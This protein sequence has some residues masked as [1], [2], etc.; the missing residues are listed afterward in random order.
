M[1][2]RSPSAPDVKTGRKISTGAAAAPW[3][4]AIR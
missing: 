1:A 4:H 2:T 3:T